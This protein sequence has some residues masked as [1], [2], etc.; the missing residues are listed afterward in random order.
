MAAPATGFGYGERSSLNK[1]SI[2]PGPGAYTT[3]VK[4]GEAP[5]YFMGAKIEDLSSIKRAK[6]VPGPG[7]YNPVIEFTKRKDGCFSVGRGMRQP[8]DG[9]KNFVPGPGNY[10]DNNVTVPS[11]KGTPSFSFGSGKRPDPTG[12]KDSPPGPGHYR[13]RSTFA[14][15]PKYL[16]TN[17]DEKHKLV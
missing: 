8:L 16:I 6:D 12:K 3:P 10:L 4:I 2:V 7:Q 15:V 9:K 13:L 1:S 5:K 11:L 14:D 17:Q